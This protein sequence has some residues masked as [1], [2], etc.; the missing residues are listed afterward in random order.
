MQTSFGCAGIGESGAATVNLVD[1]ITLPDNAADVYTF[2]YEPTPGYAGSVTGRLSSITLP[3]GGTITYT[4]SGGCNGSGIMADGTTAGLTRT[5]SDGT[6]TYARAPVNGNATT[7][8]TT[9]EA[10]NITIL[11]F[12]KDTTTS[13][14]F[15]THRQVYQGTNTSGGNLLDQYTCYNGGTGNCDGAGMALPITSKVIIKSYNNQAQVQTNETYQDGLLTSSIIK[16]P[17]GAV[18]ESSNLQR[19]GLGEVL[20][21]AIFDP[22]N[23]LVSYV[24]YGYDETTPLATS[25]LP[26]HFTAA[27]QGNLTSSTVYT[28]TNAT[29]RTTYTNDDAG[30][31]LSIAAPNGTTSIRYD[32]TDT[33]ETGRTL[34]TPSSGV[35]LAT[36]ASYNAAAGV[37]LTATGFNPNQTVTANTYDPLLRPTKISLPIQGS[38]TTITYAPSQ[39]SVSAAISGSQSSQKL[40]TM[41]GYGRPVR[42]AIWNGSVYYITDSCYGPTGL[43]KSVGL[44]YANSTLPAGYTCTTRDTYTYDALSRPLSVQHAD[45][46]S[47]SW[48]YNGLAVKQVDSPGAAK[49]TQYDMLGRVA[50]VCELSSNANMPGSGAP[51]ACNYDIGGT[52][53]PTLY[54]YNLA[55]HTTT[56]T[57][58]AQQR[59]FTT[60]M[61]GRTIS[62]Q[63]PERGAASYTY[64][65]NTAGLVVTRNRPTANQTSASALTTTTTQFDSLNRPVTITY[66]DGT[67]T[68]SFLY[69]TPSS[70]WYE[71]GW[72]YNLVGHLSRAYRATAAGPAGTLFSYD[73][74]GNVIANY[75]CEPS[76]CGTPSRDQDINYG[77]DWTGGL[78]SESDGSG[79]TYTYTRSNAGEVTGITASP[80]DTTHLANIVMPGSV[81]NGPFG[82]TLYTLGNGLQQ[83]NTYDSMGRLNGGY[84]CGNST[85]IS[86]N[87]GT[88]FYG[89]QA[90]WNGSQLTGDSDTVLN[91]GSSYGYD[92]FS[93]LASS[94]TTWG[95]VQNLTWTYD[96]YGNRWQQ[97]APQ[98]GPQP[99]LTFNT[100]NNQV[101]GDSYD[102]AG[103]LLSDGVHNYA[104]DADGNLISVDNG[105]TAVYTYNALNQRIVVN[106]P[107]RGTTEFAYDDT[108]HRVSTWNAPG[109]SL[110]EGNAYWNGRPVAF[111]SAGSTHF[112][113]QDWQGTERLRTSYSGTVDSN[114]I[115][116]PFGDGYHASGN[117]WDWYHFAGLTHDPDSGTEAA[118]FRQYSSRQGHW[119]SPDPY[120]GDN[121]QSLNRYAY[122]LNSPTSYL[123]PLGLN[124][125]CYTTNFYVDGHFDS[126]E[127]NC[128]DY[129]GGGGG[130]GG[131]D[132]GGSGG[133]GGIAP[134]KTPQNPCLHAGRALPPSAY[135]AQGAADKGH[136]GNFLADTLQGFPAGHFLDPQPLSS[137]TVQQAAAYGNY[138]YG[139]FMQ[140]SGLSLS[141]TLYAANVYAITRSS[142][143]SGTQYDDKYLGLPVSNVANITNGYLAQQNGVT[144]HN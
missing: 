46:S 61:A 89:F 70:G 6:K 83:V 19:N 119:M 77:R 29:L 73:L 120:D 113:H 93:R 140:A 17:S 125:V 135:A 122:V 117:D 67:I 82:P 3:T 75:E 128:I 92:E 33:F 108:G 47:T 55:T 30:Q 10:N 132:G 34:P 88:Q 51:S 110:N 126:S 112:E 27:S 76:G 79:T 18:L 72:Q 25:G 136:I 86:C 90:N 49:I 58:G 41:D 16:T 14:Y 15:E 32:A 101:A 57:Q 96:R 38:G 109:G 142:Y 22:S 133:N 42:S 68:K 66:T 9:D 71:A 7:T 138:T 39:T 31:V 13:N 130:G 102:A 111:K 21:Q 85:A 11:H 94:T 26:Q 54:A 28:A 118:T 2:N 56:V 1:H 62:T 5:T 123:D 81:Q 91:R 74:N 87:G 124:L 48:S 20:S 98:G 144:C 84:T 60:D 36:S 107:A 137:G 43:V 53:F 141:Q 103:N 80:S 12:S 104:Y 44:P 114:Y 35:T 24:T 105:S 129:G 40:T 8:T 97:N 121:P 134:D 64:T 23:A 50:A 99:Q 69:D 127:T 131:G 59:V 78:T 139:V 4:Y 45:G 106:I 65:Y 143:P 95:A 100:A 115:S 63:E 116:L 52:G 37:P